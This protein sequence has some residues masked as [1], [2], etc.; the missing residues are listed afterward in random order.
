[1]YVY[2][3]IYP[4]PAYIRATRNSGGLVCGI[5]CCG[6]SFP[7][8]PDKT[9]LQFELESKC[10]LQREITICSSSEGFRGTGFMVIRV[11]L[12]CKQNYCTH[13]PT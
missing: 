9:R 5:C 4:C 8:L 2:A 7:K 1:M 11:L 10:C 12:V 3:C 13:T 6:A